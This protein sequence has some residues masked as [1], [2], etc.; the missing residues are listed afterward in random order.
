MVQNLSPRALTD[1]DAA[2]ERLDLF[3][4]AVLSGTSAASHRLRPPPTGWPRT[5]GS[6]RP[7]WW[8]ASPT[9]C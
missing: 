1:E 3:E 6:P 2:A 9:T 8:W 4:I 7:C 5:H